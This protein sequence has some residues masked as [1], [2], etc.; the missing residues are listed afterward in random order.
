[1][2]YF[3]GYT[4]NNLQSI[5]TIPKFQNRAAPVADIKLWSIKSNGTLWEIKAE[6]V[7]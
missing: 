2:N 6:E 1:M 5:L 4:G 7:E 3:F